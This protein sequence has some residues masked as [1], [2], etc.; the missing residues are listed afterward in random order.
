M[1]EPEQSPDPRAAELAERLRQAVGAFVRA[2]RQDADI[3]SSA[4]AET[5]ALLDREGP[6]NVATLAQMRGVKHQTM[7]LIAAQLEATALVRSDPD[8]ADRRSR[9]LSISDAGRTELT[10][11]R[12]ARASR[13]EE[14]I[15]TSLSPD[16][17][18]I[19][20]EAVALLERM[21]A[22]AGR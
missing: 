14:L 13:I 1:H 8:P 2:V 3:G 16:E 6:R 5:L 10:R 21:S 9:L 12:Q 15:R 22:S 4:Q 18:D 19:L 20:G 17:R 11:G 7:R